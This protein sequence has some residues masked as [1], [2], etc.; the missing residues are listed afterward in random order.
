MPAR[1]VRTPEL[2][3]EVLARIA[4]GEPLAA[5]L[6][7]EGKPHQTT[8][9]EWLREDEALAIAH[10]H[11]REAG[12]EVIAADSLAI[13]DAPPERV[14]TMQGDERTESRID[15]AAVQWAKNR[16][17]HRLKLL[18]KWH[19]SRYGDKVQTEHTGTVALV[20]AA[21]ID[22]KL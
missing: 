1:S 18:A 11:A 15:S 22:E 13:I 8:W 10:T 16:A 3:Q 2:V 4:Q 21:S 6:R 7:E 14:V 5:I 17:E 12:F 20:Q 19:P 9:N